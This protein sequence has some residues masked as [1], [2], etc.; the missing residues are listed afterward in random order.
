MKRREFIT[1]IDDV[2]ACGARSAK[3]LAPQRFTP[4]GLADLHDPQN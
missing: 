3:M 2:A 4:A 1:L